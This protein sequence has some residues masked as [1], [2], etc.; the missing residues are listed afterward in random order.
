MKNRRNNPTQAQLTRRQFAT[1]AVMTGTLAAAG[2]GMTLPA[3]A[4]RDVGVD[5]L[6]APGP[7]PDITIG[8]KNAKVTLVEYASMSCPACASF[9]K[10][11]MPKLKKRYIDTGKVLLVM[12]EFPLNEVAVAVS[13]LTRCAGDNDKMAA[14][15]DVYFEHQDKWLVRGNLVPK[16]F[17]LARQAGFTRE[18]FEKCLQ[19]QELSK[20]LV[21]QRDIASREFGVSRTPSFFVNGK[22]LQGNIMSIDTFSSAFEPLLQKT[23]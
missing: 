22:A 18:T 15:I 9:H 5:K 17:E 7:L 10:N 11:V 12:R 4:Q 8:N 2:A 13:M 19:D 21:K 6:M 20:K 14:L 16:L 3:A 1:G 23:G